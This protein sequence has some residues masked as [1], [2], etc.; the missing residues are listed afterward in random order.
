MLAGGGHP[1]AI[2]GRGMTMGTPRFRDWWRKI[3]R[4]YDVRANIG[5]EG[6]V[7]QKYET[8]FATRLPVID[9]VAPYGRAQVTAV[10][11]TVAD[12]LDAVEVIRDDQATATQEA[13]RA[14]AAA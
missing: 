3:G 14:R 12:L 7:Y 11:A 10:V 6:K 5:I 9:K 4:E 13:G 8:N 2:V 1:V